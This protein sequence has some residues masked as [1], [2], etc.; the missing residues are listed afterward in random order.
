MQFRDVAAYHHINTVSQ[1][2]VEDPATL[3][4]ILGAV[5]SAGLE[6]LL[7][8]YGRLLVAMTSDPPNKLM[9]RRL[10]GGLE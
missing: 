4:N 7:N 5:G 2:R 3:L 6:L 10:R 9:V 8:E 1:N